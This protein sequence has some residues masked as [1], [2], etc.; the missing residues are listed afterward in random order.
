MTFKKHMKGWYT[1]EDGR[2]NIMERNGAWELT[3]EFVLERQWGFG[4]EL[5]D[6]TKGTY[7]CSFQRLKSAKKCVEEIV[8]NY[9][10]NTRVCAYTN[11]Y[12]REA[13][14][15]AKKYW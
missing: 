13:R 12:R 15:I 1:S 5:L 4:G 9:P 14:Q 11:E 6:F 3:D 2:F 8:K 7:I 10:L